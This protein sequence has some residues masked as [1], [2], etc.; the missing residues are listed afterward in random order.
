[1][2]HTQLHQNR[3]LQCN[4]HLIGGTLTLVVCLLPIGMV[5]LLL[6]LTGVNMVVAKDPLFPNDTVI[7]LYASLLISLID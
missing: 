1:N 2:A 7:M 6:L 5:L 4:M 3:L